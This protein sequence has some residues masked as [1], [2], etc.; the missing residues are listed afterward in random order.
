[1]FG[2]FSI[3][4][5]YSDDY[6]ETQT[7]MNLSDLSN[8]KSE[9][10][11]HVDNTVCNVIAPK[12]LYSLLQSKL[13]SKNYDSN[14]VHI[15]T[16]VANTFV[17]SIVIEALNNRDRRANMRERSISQED[18][19]ISLATIEEYFPLIE[20]S[21]NKNLI[22][23]ELYEKCTKNKVMKEEISIKILERPT[24]NENLCESDDDS[25]ETSG[26]NINPVF[27]E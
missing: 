5:N 2:M 6:D 13:G 27:L 10:T 4:N 18:L 14:I 26:F 20:K 22:N 9:S 7:V 11:H 16:D 15:L 21:V 8:Q 17:K 25:E 3:S 24:L 1:M 23:S 19:Y 12:N